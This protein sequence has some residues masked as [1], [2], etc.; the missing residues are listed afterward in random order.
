MKQIYILLF[1]IFLTSNSVAAQ[2]ELVYWVGGNTS[3]LSYPEN[4]QGL[5]SALNTG[6]QNYNG[7]NTFND[8][9]TAWNN[10]IINIC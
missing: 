10:P 7:L 6:I 3:T 9:R 1:S 2:E 5:S 8:P 4:G